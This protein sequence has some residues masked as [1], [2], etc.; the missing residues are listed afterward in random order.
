META[1]TTLATLVFTSCGVA[2][3]SGKLY[4]LE[5]KRTEFEKKYWAVNTNENFR[6]VKTAS[7]GKYDFKKGE[8][9]VTTDLFFDDI[10][11]TFPGDDLP[12]EVRLGSFNKKA[13]GNNIS[14]YSGVGTKATLKI[15][16]TI[17]IIP[18]YTKK[19]RVTPESFL[20]LLLVKSQSLFLRLFSVRILQNLRVSLF[21][22][23]FCLRSGIA[24][25]QN[26]HLFL[27]VLQQECMEF[28]VLE[29]FS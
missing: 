16:Q 15:R 19:T 7:L 24:R 23:A 20:L 21:L 13:W 12:L 9:N 4:L 8:F 11:S 29:K 3:V 18:A 22:V 26:L 1:N 28:C 14:W 10:Q 6:V 27:F 5:D 25:K 17:N 2:N